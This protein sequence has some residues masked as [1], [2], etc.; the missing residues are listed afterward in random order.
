MPVTLRRALTLSEMVPAKKGDCIFVFG[1][2]HNLQRGGGG[3]AKV[4][5]QP[6]GWITITVT[7][8]L[9]LGVVVM[10]CIFHL[11]HVCY[12][13]TDQLVFL[14]MVGIL[15]LHIAV[16]SEREMWRTGVTLLTGVLPLLSLYL[17]VMSVSPC[18]GT[19]IVELL[20]VKAKC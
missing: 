16:T 13:S 1:V 3:N 17:S 8:E 4:V 5:H 10:I 15:L 19:W 14:H 6:H 18:G 12:Q 7:A 2:N 9:S 20:A 11:Q